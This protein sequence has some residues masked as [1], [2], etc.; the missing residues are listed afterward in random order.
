MRQFLHCGYF[1]PTYVGKWH[2]TCWQA[3]GICKE[4]SHPVVYARRRNVTPGHWGVM[5]LWL[6][7]WF[8]ALLYVI[9]PCW[10]S[11]EREMPWSR[12]KKQHVALFER[13]CAVSHTS[14]QPVIKQY[15]CVFCCWI[16]LTSD[17]IVIKFIWSK[18]VALFAHPLCTQMEK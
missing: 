12:R 16:C 1:H 11:K 4:W 17:V 2:F 6:W 7:R 15:E 3:N 14:L 5:C 8:V 13:H 10:S 18:D 9:W